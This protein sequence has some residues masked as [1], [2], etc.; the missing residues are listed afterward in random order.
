MTVGAIKSDCATRKLQINPDHR[1]TK[2]MIPVEYLFPLPTYEHNLLQHFL[3]R[4]ASSYEKQ[5]CK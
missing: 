5:L 4:F 2:F 3:S 1:I